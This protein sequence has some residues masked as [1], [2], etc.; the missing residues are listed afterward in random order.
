[1]FS[2]CSQHTLS[3][4]LCFFLVCVFLNEE[5]N[6]E[7]RG[8]RGEL[9]S[10]WEVQVQSSQCFVSTASLNLNQFAG[11]VALRKRASFV[12]LTWLFWQK[13]SL[14]LQKNAGSSTAPVEGRQEYRRCTSIYTG[15]LVDCHQ[16]G[17]LLLLPVSS[18]LGKHHSIVTHVSGF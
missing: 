16:S 12:V 4:V 6:A 11:P 18:A 3:L 13:I 8:E 9:R 10:F 1:M 14:A 5:K 15:R 17:T 7:K 2:T